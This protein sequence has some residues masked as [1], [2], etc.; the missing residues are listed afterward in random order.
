MV[1]YFLLV[2]LFG[3]EKKGKKVTYFWM[4]WISSKTI[5]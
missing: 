5:I 2:C 1:L 3:E 4:S